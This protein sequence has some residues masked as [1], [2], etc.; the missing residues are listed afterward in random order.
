MKT[1]TD[2]LKPTDILEIDKE[3]TELNDYIFNLFRY[4]TKY[5][6][7]ADGIKEHF[8]FYLE[9]VDCI[10][11]AIEEIAFVLYKPTEYIP[12][13]DWIE[14]EKIINRTFDYIDYNRWLN[15][16]QLL[17]SIHFPQAKEY[18]N[19]KRYSYTWN[20][21]SELEWSEING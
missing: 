12:K 16:I 21:E 13:K 10:E 17:K 11:K 18:W 6:S 9:D 7:V 8:F 3:I 1:E 15:N 20:E 4:V 2:I 5:S 14:S 19:L